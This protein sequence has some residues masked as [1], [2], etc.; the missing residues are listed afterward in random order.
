MIKVLIV[1]DSITQREILKQVLEADGEFV[2]V[3]EAR[4]GNQ[5]V[6]M[7]RECRPDV[8]LMDIHMPEMDGI[9]ATR[10]VM[11]QCPVPIVVASATLR[12][13]D[14]DHGL[15][16]IEAGAVSMISKPDGAAL[17]HLKKIAPELRHELLAAAQANVARLT[18]QAAPTVKS[19]PVPQPQVAIRKSQLIE[20]IGVC[21]STGGPS[22]LSEIF[23]NLPKPYPIPILLVQHISE[24]FVDG[25]GEWMASQT[26]QSVGIAADGQRLT[27]GIWLAPMRRHLA[28]AS[29]TRISLPHRKSADVHC[30]SGEQLFESMARHLGPRAV[31]VQLTGMGNDG[32]QGL[33]TLKEAGGETIIQSEATSLIWGMPKVA[34]ELGAANHEFSP[35]AIA[36]VL[37]RLAANR[38][39]P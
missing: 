12:R 23:G 14:V 25:F 36:G 16:A 20:A 9:E 11:S 19:V 15:Q 6:Q 27:P 29:S 33:L 17:L 39:T 10:Q 22:V 28:L 31:G 38:G 37:T 8:V 21:A 2:V 7:V 24:G 1:D 4:D 13:R 34:K 5:V 35:M 32:A 18:Q 3:G 26:K 30:P